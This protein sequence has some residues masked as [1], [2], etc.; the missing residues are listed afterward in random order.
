MGCYNIHFKRGGVDSQPSNDHL[1][2]D[3]DVWVHTIGEQGG[4]FGL[5]N[6]EDHYLCLQVN[7][8]ISNPYIKLIIAKTRAR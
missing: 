5:G 1:P 4:V 7:H 2:S 8:Q 3:L 6:V